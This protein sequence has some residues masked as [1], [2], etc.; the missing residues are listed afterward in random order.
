MSAD[1]QSHNALPLLPVLDFSL[2][3]TGLPENRRKFAGQIHM[4]VIKHGFFYLEGHG[5]NTYIAEAMKAADWFFDLPEAEKSAIAIEKSSCHRGWYAIGGERLD[6]EAHPEG[7]Y[8]EGLKIGQDLPL[9]HPFVLKN[10]PLHGPNLWLAENRDQNCPARDFNTSMKTAY[11]HLSDLS[12]ELMRAFATGLNLPETYFDRYLETPMATLS[13][14][15]Y[16]PL[17]ASRDR[18]SAGAHTDFGCLSLLAQDDTGG[19]EILHPEAGWMAVPPRPDSLV[20]NIGDMLSLWTGG[21][22]RSTTHRVR[23]VSGKQR[24]SMVFFFD[25]QYDTPLDD[26]CS[27]TVTDTPSNGL[28]ALQH[29]LNM[30]SSSFKHVDFDD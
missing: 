9:T 13:P 8:K 5:L 23:N 24:N 2:F 29:L 16:P 4:A 1:V 27:G 19:L 14:I 21:L 20:V 18:I 25:P 17:P 15:R 7:D 3:M 10:L 11:H 28:T 22:Y 26:I 30:I 12:A 6:A